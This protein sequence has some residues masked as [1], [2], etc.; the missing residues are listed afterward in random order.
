MALPCAGSLT[1][2]RYSRPSNVK[3]AP[4]MRML[5]PCVDIGRAR[6]DLERARAV[7]ETLASGA[8]HDHGALAL[9]LKRD[10]FHDNGLARERADREGKARESAIPQVG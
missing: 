3:R 4:A 7:A 1:G 10:E 9:R 2:S 8:G 5:A 6:D